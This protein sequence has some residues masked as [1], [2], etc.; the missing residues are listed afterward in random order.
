MPRRKKRILP[1]WKA[2]GQ[3]WKSVR[4]TSG[5][6]S[7][8]IQGQKRLRLI[9]YTCSSLEDHPVVVTKPEKSRGFH[10]RPSRGRRVPGKLL[11]QSRTCSP[12][13]TRTVKMRLST[14][15]FHRVKLHHPAWTDPVQRHRRRPRG[16]NQRQRWSHREVVHLR[17]HAYLV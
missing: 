12:P 8:R 1:F 15:H 9:L 2:T 10:S 5:A 7:L 4:Q 6:K 11:V 14:L 13:C 16:K 3:T 17:L